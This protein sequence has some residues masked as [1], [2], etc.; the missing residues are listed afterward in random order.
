MAN[1]VFVDGV[2]ED[3]SR[4][5]A[6]TFDRAVSVHGAPFLWDDLNQRR[7]DC[8][9]TVRECLRVV[10]PGGHVAFVGTTSGWRK[11]HE[12]E[13]AA[14]QAA[15][16]VDDPILALL[17]PHGFAVRDIGVVMDYGSV[18]EALATYGFIYGKTAI[19]YIRERQTSRLGW[20]LRI[21]H[22]AM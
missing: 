9:A 22:R 11:D 14:R 7:R 4:F 17:A 18:D 15:A 6:S 20:S 2:A 21:Y 5:T 12:R 10:K 13:S 1:V 16:L 8:E 19:D 3:L